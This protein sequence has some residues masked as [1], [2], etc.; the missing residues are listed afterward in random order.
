MTFSCGIH[1]YYYY[2][3]GLEKQKKET[4]VN[5]SIYEI[6]ERHSEWLFYAM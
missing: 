4:G 1:F 3:S 2:D 5:T 6:M